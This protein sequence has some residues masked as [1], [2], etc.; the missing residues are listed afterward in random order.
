MKLDMWSYFYQITEPLLMQSYVTLFFV[1]FILCIVI[2]IASGYGF[3]RR[4][5]LDAVAIQS[6][7]RGFVPRVGGLAVF[8]SILVLIPLLSFGFIPLSVVFNLNTQQI[9]VLILSAVPVF[10]V[11]LAEDLGYAMSSKVRLTAS[12]ISGFVAIL[13]FKVWLTRLGIPGLDMLLKFVP[14]AIL[15]TIFAT[16]GVVNAFNLIDGLHGLSSY[17]AISVALSLSII[18]F[19]AGDTQIT[20][21]LVLIIASVLGFMILNFP[22]GKIFLGDGGAYALGHLLVWS[23]IIL[24]NTSMKVSPF[25]ILL[26]FFWPVADT[27]LAIWRRWKSGSPTDRPD[28]LHLH[29]L[30]MRFL[31][32]RFF[33]RDRRK[34]ANPIAT[35][36]LIPLISVPQILGI[37]FWDNFVTSVWCTLGI[38][39]LFV[40]TYFLGINIAKTSRSTNG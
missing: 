5:T 17:V 25:S 27:G 23:A 19:K 35:I 4:G 11:G 18:G 16:V 14:F 3:S 8:L 39:L 9:T 20:I 38:G 24:I 33:G 1:S 32:I 22:L 40:A 12:A 26:I 2:I 13:L 21:F 7:H 36:V 6:A 10:F 37:L 15:F 34:I 29:Q 31:E 28:R 30:A